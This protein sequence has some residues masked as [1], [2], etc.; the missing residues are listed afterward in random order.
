MIVANQPYNGTLEDPGQL[1]GYVKH[2][3]KDFFSIEFES[4]QLEG[5]FVIFQSP[6]KFQIAE[7]DFIVLQN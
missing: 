6:Q 3:P 2:P 7:I 4:C 1:C 5:E